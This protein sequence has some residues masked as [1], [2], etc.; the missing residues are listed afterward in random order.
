MLSVVFAPQ[1]TWLISGSKVSERQRSVCVCV[2]VRERERERERK[3]SCSTVSQVLAYCTLFPRLSLLITSGEREREREKERVRERGEE[4]EEERESARTRTSFPR[5]IVAH[6]LRRR[7][8]DRESARARL[9]AR[10]IVA[11]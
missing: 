6:E 8:R 10:L 1:G 11:H 7:E 5:L 3:E 4:R 2:C 9:F